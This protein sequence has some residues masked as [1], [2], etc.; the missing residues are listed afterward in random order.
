LAETLLA[1]VIIGIVASYT[2]PGLIANIQLTQRKAQVK[3]AY[4]I[5]TE[6]TNKVLEENN[7]TMIGLLEVG[8]TDNSL[9]SHYI[10]YLNIAKACHHS[11]TRGNCWH[12]EGQ[13]TYDDG[14]PASQATWEYVGRG[15]VLADG[16]FFAIEDLWP[17]CNSNPWGDNGDT[18]AYAHYDVNGFKGPNVYGK[19]IFNFYIIKDRII[20]DGTSYYGD[21][22][23]C[24]DGTYNCHPA[25]LLTN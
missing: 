7:G 17:D 19:D 8:W 4:A 11:D 24:H 16:S 13:A 25:Y 15:I 21:M 5:L 20:P 22:A 1:I 23:L 12:L 14:T 10:P 2:I 9:M 6:A 18:C 3:K